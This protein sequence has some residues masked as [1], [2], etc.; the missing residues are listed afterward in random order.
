DYDAFL[1][2]VYDTKSVGWSIYDYNTMAS[3]AWPR[4]RTGGVP[5]TTTTTTTTTAPRVT[6]KAAPVPTACAWARGGG[7]SGGSGGERD[8]RGRQQGRD[9]VAVRDARRAPRRRAGVREGDEVLPPGAVGSAA[10][11]AGG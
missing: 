5:T 6:S 7:G 2:A 10:R 3:S 1:R 8:H 11:S 9:H 4:M